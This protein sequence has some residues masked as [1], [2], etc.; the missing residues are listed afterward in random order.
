MLV[1]NFMERLDVRLARHYLIGVAGTIRLIYPMWVAARP[2]YNHCQNVQINFAE[3]CFNVATGGA[4]PLRRPNT[5]RRQRLP[6]HE[7]T[8]RRTGAFRQLGSPGLL[9][10]GP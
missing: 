8:G 3:R 2:P 10:A 9:P 1:P 4:A 6:I 5:S 7:L